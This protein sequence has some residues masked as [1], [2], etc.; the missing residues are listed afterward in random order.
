M[1]M[2][3]SKKM[4]T[5][6]KPGQLL[7]HHIEYD[8]Q[9]DGAHVTAIHAPPAG[10]KGD[11]WTPGPSPARKS[12]S[13]RLDAHHHMLQQ[14]GVN[15]EIAGEASAARAHGAPD[16]SDPSGM[17]ESEGDDDEDQAE[18]RGGASDPASSVAISKEPAPKRK[19]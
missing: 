9:G 16:S 8:Q 14:A 6:P 11:P 4:P 19:I 18:S 5:G 1:K 3:V 7:S 12:F 15:A 10:K 17:G 2:T 13:N